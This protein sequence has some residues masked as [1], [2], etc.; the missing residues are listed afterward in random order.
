MFSGEFAPITE[1]VCERMGRCLEPKELKGYLH[2]A[3]S[4]LTDGDKLDF[5]TGLA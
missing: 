3:P 5:L 2:F 4:D 1:A